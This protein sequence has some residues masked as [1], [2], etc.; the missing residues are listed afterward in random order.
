MVTV[1]YCPYFQLDWSLP[2]QAALVY[3]ISIKMSKSCV[4]FVSSLQKMISVGYCPHVQLG[5]LLPTQEA[6]VYMMNMRMSKSCIWLV[7]SLQ[8]IISVGLLSSCSIWL[9]VTNPSSS[10]LYNEYEMRMS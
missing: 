7:F 1:G 3:I 8:K 10:S 4:W 9:V 6:L 5:W 2:T